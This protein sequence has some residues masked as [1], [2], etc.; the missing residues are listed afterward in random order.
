MTERDEARRDELPEHETRPIEGETV[1][2]GVM[3]E[4]GTAINR[5]TGDLEGTAQGPYANEDEDVEPV[6]EG[7][8]RRGN[9]LSDAETPAAPSHPG[10]D[11]TR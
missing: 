5:G 9:P 1:G 8:G 11:P 7:L 6:D 10:I 2:G 3:G 4:G